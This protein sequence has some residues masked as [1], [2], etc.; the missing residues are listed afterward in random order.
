MLFRDTFETKRGLD[1]MIAY[2]STSS[3]LFSL[4]IGT[5]A[6]TTSRAEEAT[7]ASMPPARWRTAVGEKTRAEPT[8]PYNMHASTRRSRASGRARPASGRYSHHEGAAGAYRAAMMMGDCCRIV[9]DKVGHARSRMRGAFRGAA[10]QLPARYE[11]ECYLRLDGISPRRRWRKMPPASTRNCVVDARMMT[12]FP[13][14]A[15]VAGHASCHAATSP[16][17]CAADFQ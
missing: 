15:L 3:P 4:T 7:T 6:F 1:E 2:S 5:I 8:Q 10:A 14:D 11:I 13:A 9:L 17:R 12:R 16:M